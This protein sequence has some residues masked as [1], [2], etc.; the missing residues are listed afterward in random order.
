MWR[1]YKLHNR[2]HKRQVAI[3][4]KYENHVGYKLEKDGWD[5]DYRGKHYGKYDRG[6]DLIATKGEVARYIQCKARDLGHGLREDV[7]NQFAG[8]VE[9]M[10]GER[11]GG[12]LEAYIYTTVEPTA[13]AYDFAKRHGIKIV[14]DQFYRHHQTGE[15]Q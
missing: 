4:R 13:V 6:I 15:K 8:S 9:A 7:V 12:N 11:I 2:H 14:V 3:G 1:H 10:S 5:V